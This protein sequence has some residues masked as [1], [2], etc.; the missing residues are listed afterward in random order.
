MNK[1]TLLSPVLVKRGEAKEWGL[2]YMGSLVCFE[3][4]KPYFPIGGKGAIDRICETG[5]VSGC[6]IYLMKLE[7]IY[8]STYRI[9]A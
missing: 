2:M 8:D 5:L 1:Q 4:N 6:C 3:R 9:G 7:W